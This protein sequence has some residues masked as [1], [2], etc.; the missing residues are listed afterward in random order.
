MLV[1]RYQYQMLVYERGV[2][3]VFNC[4]VGRRTAIQVLLTK[5]VRSDS[6]LVRVRARCSLEQ[7]VV[8][9]EPVVAHDDDDHRD[10]ADFDSVYDT[11]DVI[12]F[13]VEFSR[14]RAPMVR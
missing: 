7:A 6:I 13:H 10:E 9:V 11:E 2:D 3:S 12:A 14:S 4:K 5:I 1:H 8:P